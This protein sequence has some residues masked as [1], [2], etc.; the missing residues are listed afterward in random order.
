MTC[1]AFTDGNKLLDPSVYKLE[2]ICLLDTTRNIAMNN[3]SGREEDRL[4][5]C[6]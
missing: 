1:P 4:C 2:V 3:A 6:T 5:H